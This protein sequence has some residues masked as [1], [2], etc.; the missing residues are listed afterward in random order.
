MLR[1][2]FVIIISITS[3]AT[4]IHYIEGRKSQYEYAA[5]KVVINPFW[6]RVF[7][8]FITIDL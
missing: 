3:N 4:G 5:L 2:G 6:A 7:A 8:E 1:T